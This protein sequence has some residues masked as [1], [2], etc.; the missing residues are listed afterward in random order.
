MNI[1]KLVVGP[2][3]VINDGSVVSLATLSDV[4]ISD[5]Q[6][7]QILTYDEALNK[8]VN[9]D[10]SGGGGGAVASVNGLTG[11]V[12]LTKTNIGLGNVSN[13]APADLGISTATQ[14]ALDLK[15]TPSQAAAAAP[16]QSVAGKTGTV[17][18]IKSDV[19]LGSVDNTADSAKPISTAQQTALDGKQAT[20]TATTTADYYRGDKTF[21]TLN[22]TAVGLGNVD[23]TADVSK[24]ISTLTQSALDLKATI[25]QLNGKL[26]IPTGNP[27][28]QVLNGVGVPVLKPRYE[29]LSA[30]PGDLSVYPDGS[31]IVITG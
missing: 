11:V 22:K 18:L 30:L 16:V 23:N 28:T 3:Q 19:G 14:T 31:R 21:A 1:V 24:P 25:I 12:V 17:T 26:T 2:L 8:W 4:A 5:L 6:D 7:L 27:T 20:I 9:I 15:T 29:V 13:L 10:N